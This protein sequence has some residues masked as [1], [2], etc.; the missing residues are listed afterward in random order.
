MEAF[1]GDDKPNPAA[2]IGRLTLTFGEG[3]PMVVWLDGTWKAAREKAAGWLEAGFDDSKWLAAKI[4]APYGRGPW[5]RLDGR[6]LTLSPVSK[7]TPYLGFCEIPANLLSGNSVI[8]LEMEGMAP[9]AAARVT[10]NGRYAGGV[11]G[12]PLRLPITTFLTPGRN[13]IRIEPF[14]P[15]SAQLVVQ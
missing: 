9:E 10:I 13:E 1:N 7:A 5:G 8:F 3:E 15:T 2:V 12:L 11:I 6:R 14:A 4:V